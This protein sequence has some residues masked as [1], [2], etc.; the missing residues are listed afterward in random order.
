MTARVLGAINS[1][2]AMVGPRAYRGAR[3]P[4]ESLPILRQCGA[5]YDQQVVAALDAVVHSAF[6]EKLL[7]QH[8]KN[9]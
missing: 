4:D 7:A 5:A 1:F 6:G 9:I 2:C 3:T 8:A